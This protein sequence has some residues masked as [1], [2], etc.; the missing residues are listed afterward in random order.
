M[1]DANEIVSALGQ[2]MPAVLRWAGAV[3]KQL[4][5]HDIA[6][7]GKS[8][9]FSNTDALTLADLSLQELIVAA[10]RDGDPSFRRCRIE[11]EEATGD[12]ARFAADS[13]YVISIDPIDGTKQ[14]RDRSGDGWSVMLHLRTAT[15][16]LYSL[17]SIPS[18]GV[19]GRWVEVT[20]DRIAVGD[21][22]LSRPARE[23]LDALPNV[24]SETPVAG[25]SIYMIGF[26][27][28][29]WESV[30]A[31]RSAGVDGVDADDTPGCLYDL[32]ATRRFAGS[33]IHSP[34][35]YDYPVSLQ[36]ARRFGGDSVSVHTGRPVDF[37]DLWYDERSKMWRLK[38]VVATATDPELL[39]TLCSVARDWNQ[40][41]YAG[42]N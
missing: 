10:L 19:E 22:D 41:R 23:V 37:N 18:A 40:D 9:G 27:G 17:V 4:R 12:L 36:I 8:S 11:A 13:P 16:V 24:S 14:Y 38:G 28:R 20:P 33:L 3:A 2:H 21:D 5:T 25:A 7:G 26:V 6:V 35:V 32:M 31:V 30:D 34:N 39:E 42:T 1:T 29:E 15:D